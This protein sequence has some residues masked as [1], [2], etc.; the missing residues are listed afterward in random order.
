[1]A[2]NAKTQFVLLGLI[3]DGP[4]T[5]YEIK[6]TIERSIGYFWQESYGQIYPVLHSL[7][8]ENY[9][10]KKSVTQSNKP[11]KIIYSITE[12]G[13]RL[14]NDW[15]NS[16]VSNLQYR[17]ELLLRVFFGSISDSGQIINILQEH[18]ESCTLQ[19]K[20]FLEVKKLLKTNSMVNAGPIENSTYS[21]LTLEY[22]IMNYTM[23]VQWAKKAVNELI[24]ETN[25]K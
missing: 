14:L 9:I 17:N 24:K 23:E 3:A 13:L 25:A 5:G 19:L 2:R 8:K 6:K 16:P 22:G 20:N 21:M 12:S 11:D 1:M 7:H 15:I 10:T 4:K 18:I